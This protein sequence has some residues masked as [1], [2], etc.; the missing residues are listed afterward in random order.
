MGKVTSTSYKEALERREK[1]LHTLWITYTH[2]LS[3]EQWRDIRKQ[4]GY[5][6]TD[7]WTLKN[8]R[9]TDPLELHLEKLNYKLQ[10]IHKWTQSLEAQY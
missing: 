3:I 7:L 1:K 9:L 5:F 6:N 2:E 4:K 10:Y 8:R